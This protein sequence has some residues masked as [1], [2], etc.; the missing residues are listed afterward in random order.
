[1]FPCIAD[2]KDTK[3]SERERKKI[4]TRTHAHTIREEVERNKKTN[5]KYVCIP[6]AK[7]GSQEIWNS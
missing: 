1:M 7:Q 4:N 5:L 2:E 3:R 6:P